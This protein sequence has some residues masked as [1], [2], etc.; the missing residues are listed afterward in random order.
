M[1]RSIKR[2][3]KR[4]VSKERRRGGGLVRRSGLAAGA[5]AGAFALAAPAAQA[6]NLQVDSLADGPADGSC[7]PPDCT[8]RDAFQLANAGNDPDTITFLSS[9]SGTINLSSGVLV[10]FGNYPMTIDG[11]GAG[12]LTVSGDGDNNGSPND[13]VF[14][15]GDDGVNDCGDFS[16]EG[17]TLT[18]GT[19]GGGTNRGGALFTYSTC[20]YVTLTNVTV[21]DSIS[22]GEGGGVFADEAL[23]L[24]NT[25][26]SG[27]QSTGD[28]G[29]GVF[30]DDELTVTGSTISGNTAAG[31]GGGTVSGK[32]LLIEDSEITGNHAG[33]NGGGA[34][35]KY[36]PFS[37]P[38]RII[39]D[40]TISANTAAGSGA[41]LHLPEVGVSERVRIVQSTVTQNTGGAGSDGGGIAVPAVGGSFAL[42]NSTVSGNSAEEGGGLSLGKHAPLTYGGIGE[43]ELNN[44]TIARN[45]ATSTRGGGIYL[46][47]Y[48]TGSGYESGT[49]L[50]NSTIVADNTAG[51]AAQDLDRA[52]GSSGGGFDTAFSL[53]ERKGDAPVIT[54]G[55]NL[56][57]LDPKLGPLADNGGTTKTLMPAPSSKAIDKGDS[58]RLDVDQRGRQRVVDLGI[59]NA[60]TGNGTDIG[61]V[62]LRASELPNGGKCA[63]KKV[64]IIGAGK[65]IKGTN[66]ADVILGTNGKNVIRG[67]GGKD[68]ICGLGGNDRLI[69]G[70]GPDV[71]VGG[72][73]ADRLIGGPGKDKLKG[74]PGRDVQVQ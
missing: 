11:P 2:S 70:G 42:V 15:I 28:D 43:V 41:G 31:S 22:G 21:S 12:Q 53:I 25:T 58:S 51:G 56:L 46:G 57:G 60:P 17:L 10:R 3:H 49:V 71:L 74:G 8:L 16:V 73:G 26:I 4:R 40:S 61:S 48:N 62:E 27:N 5:A 65:K 24:V 55:P 34:R 7:G 59:P 20:S 9:L 36:S 13:R 35:I 38:R 63:G 68:R 29:G 50:V 66:G 19:A 32:Y 1:A 14:K 72:G 33:I 37:D 23:T 18:K 39:V 64:T 69:G 54:S 6:T 45:T 44:S 47:R 67:R 30:T 52:N